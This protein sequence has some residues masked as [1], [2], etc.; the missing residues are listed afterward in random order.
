M[1]RRARC[2]NRTEEA[3]QEAVTRALARSQDEDFDNYPHFCGWVV[4]TAR[5]YLIDQARKVHWTSLAGEDNFP[6]KR[7]ENT[8]PDSD[9]LAGLR[10]E[11]ALLP[12]ED[13][14]LVQLRFEEA[15][16]IADLAE[17]LGLSASAVWRRLRTVL[18]KIRAALL[19]VDPDLSVSPQ[20]KRTRKPRR[21]RT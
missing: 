17:R 1:H 18:G 19:E 4:L 16:T 15:F 13:Q 20:P 10:K 6:D 3:L 5:N 9:A 14:E 21:R 11:L 7:D 2:P 12:A 8:R